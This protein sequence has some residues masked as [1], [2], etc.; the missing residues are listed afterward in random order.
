[1]HNRTCPQCGRDLQVDLD[2]ELCADCLLAVGMESLPAMDSPAKSDPFAP[3]HAS[4]F[5]VGQSQN[6]EISIAELNQLIPH[7]EIEQLLG[8]GGMGA[9]YK[10]TQKS[11]DRT[12][13]LKVINR[14]LL[15]NDVLVDRF[16]REAKALARLH[17]PNIVGVFDFGNANGVCYLVMEYV[18]GT[19]LRQL[20]STGE[21]Q[22][23]QALEIV[24]QICE[25]LQYAHDQG[26][27]HRDIKPE[28]ILVDRGG[29]VRIADFGLAKLLSEADGNQDNLTVTRQ[30]MGTPKYMAPEQMEG[31]PE[32]DHR[33]DIY[34]LGVVFYELLTGEIPLGRFAAPS[35]K[36]PVDNRY[37][38]VVMRALEKELPNRYQHA[39]DFGI[40]VERLA[41]DVS[42][43]SSVNEQRSAAEYAYVPD[44]QVL[45]EQP[46]SD[47]DLS[48]CRT[49]VRIVAGLN[50][51]FS[52]IFLL[53]G[54]FLFFLLT[55]IG[56]A[57][58]DDEAL[59]VLPTI[60]LALGAFMSI[61]GLPGVIV[62]IGL[63]KFQNWARYG[64]LILAF[65]NLL[66]VPVGTILAIYTGWALLQEDANLLFESPQRG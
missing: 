47:Y 30:V 49:H 18:D 26:I 52:S 2:Q 6:S 48:S 22:A 59:K 9:V 21:M 5:K 3:T 25:A 27:V 15:S 40:D 56:V 4:D 44:A 51:F 57:S 65:L 62:G 8:R 43:V 45:P 7:L 39:S 50:I 34:S 64:A 29:Q 37:D 13:A 12:V 54:A 63:W 58:G 24:P 19:D 55:G 10:A 14:E 53:I 33:A 1:M 36:A 35:E 16:A 41:D 38:D 17:H 31:A 60:G 46:T 23:Q 11:L 20:L 61:L 28:N 42:P 66:N 32:I